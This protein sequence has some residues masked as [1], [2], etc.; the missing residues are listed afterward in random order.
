MTPGGTRGKVDRAEGGR[1]LSDTEE[2]GGHVHS[3]THDT[4]GPP[5]SLPCE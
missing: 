2:V 5:P 1:V 4:V 3:E